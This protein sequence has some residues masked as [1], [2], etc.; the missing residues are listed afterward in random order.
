MA[1]RPA[2]GISIGSASPVSP[3]WQGS[4]E[5]GRRQLR[6]D[7]LHRV[8]VCECVTESLQ[9]V[10][11]LQH[12][13]AFGFQRVWKCP[14]GTKVLMSNYQLSS[15]IYRPFS[16]AVKSA[17]ALVQIHLCSWKL[18]WE[19]RPDPFGNGRCPVHLSVKS[20]SSSGHA[21][22]SDWFWVI[23]LQHYWLR[24]ADADEDK[25]HLTQPE[26]I[27]GGSVSEYNLKSFKYCFEDTAAECCWDEGL[28]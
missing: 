13:Q 24:P 8:S 1:T 2:A 21:T 4:D 27:S 28:G 7:R 17:S 9:S 19:E 5:E 10:H 23:G 22:G 18:V 15:F 26:L 25:G 3:G 6:A 16:S 14:P 20:L 12:T 11:T